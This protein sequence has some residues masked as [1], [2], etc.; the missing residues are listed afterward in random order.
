MEPIH[1][2]HIPKTG[3]TAVARLPNVIKPRDHSVRLSMVPDPAIVVLRDPVERFRSAFDMYVAQRHIVHLTDI[4]EFVDHLDEV[5]DRQWPGFGFRPQSWWIDD[6][7]RDLVVLRT[8][9]LDDLYGDTLPGVGSIYRNES[10]PK[11]SLPRPAWWQPSA[12]T[13]DHAKTIARHYADDYELIRCL[14]SKQPSSTTT[15]SGS[16]PSPSAVPSRR[17]VHRV[18]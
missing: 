2:V 5:I 7:D 1:L 6:T 16:S 18:A 11:W 15:P 10:R 13:P 4:D 3:G 8:E 14:T 9:W 17:L 12:L